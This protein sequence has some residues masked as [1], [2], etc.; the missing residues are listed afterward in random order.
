MKVITHSL[1]IGCAL[2]GAC[3][4]N[5]DGADGETDSFV[6]SGKSDTA[7]TDGSPTARAVLRTASFASLATLDNTIALDA[8]AA[9]NI[10]AY[11]KGADGVAGTADDRRFTTLAQLD[12]IAYVGPVAFEHLVSFV[13]SRP[14]ADVL[15]AG[16]FRMD[17]T[18]TT[19]LSVSRWNSLAQGGPY[20][21]TETTAATRTRTFELSSDGT[22]LRIATGTLGQVTPLPETVEDGVFA[23]TTSRDGITDDGRRIFWNEA[24][25]SGTVSR[26]GEL[27]VDDL[28]EFS[29]N[30]SQIF[31]Y[32]GSITELAGP[33][34][35]ELP[36]VDPR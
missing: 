14:L 1:W 25:L 34:F 3:V 16:A 18:V 17:V 9:K 6:D 28:Y 2:L 7:I 33:A 20:N 8:R 11:R 30:G 35:G 19:P 32:S 29:G 27:V 31:G 15:P 26:L 24:Q 5:E 4:T 21:T 22:T 10:V 36:Y 13:E 23:F 12:A